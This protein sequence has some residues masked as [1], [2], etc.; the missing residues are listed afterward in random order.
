MNNDSWAKRFSAWGALFVTFSI[1]GLLGYSLYVSGAR[2]TLPPAFA[3][4]TETVKALALL[5]AG[6]WLGSSNSSQ[7]KDD[8]NAEA[9]AQALT[10]LSNSVPAHLAVPVSIAAPIVPERPE[11]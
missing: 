1:F 5:A 7:R 8:T 11:L 10:A 3:T 2:E 6:F 9:S 4:L